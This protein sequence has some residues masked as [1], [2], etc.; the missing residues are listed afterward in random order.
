MTWF[1]SIVILLIAIIVTFGYSFSVR[2]YKGKIS[3]HF[4]NSRFYNPLSVRNH[5]SGSFFKLLFTEKRPKWKN[6][7]TDSLTAKPPAKIEGNFF[8][9]YFVNHSTC[10]IQADGLNI[11]TDPVWSTH[12][13]LFGKL[14]P[15]RYR[16]P[17]IKFEDLPPI[18]IV[19][20]SHNHYD[21]MDL[22]TLKQLDQI[23]HPQFFVPL[24]NADY[25]TKKGI[26]NVI[27]M[28][29]WDKHNVD[30]TTVIECVPAQHFSG[31]GMFD[32]NKTL[33]AGFVIQTKLGNIYFAGDTGYGPFVKQ[34]ADRLQSIELAIIPIGAFK[35]RWFMQPIHNSPQDAV[36]M[37]LDLK[38]KRA[39][40][41]HFGT[42]NLA[43]ESIDEPV[44][45]LMIALEEHNLSAEQFIVLKEGESSLFYENKT[46]KIL[47]PIE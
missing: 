47:A 37:F 6:I 11:L 9:I 42:F 30:T 14:G 15:K 34:I 16:K 8:Q 13:G 46:E 44:N 10:L 21:H 24:G 7:K 36:Q 25:L 33:W 29:W 19:L 3:D 40:A 45:E 32:M 12:A 22:A 38:A 18:D 35:P 5:G 43:W 20:I 2:G 23:F 31:R 17:G 28:D 1:I 39:L 27:D 26:R 41:S 4:N